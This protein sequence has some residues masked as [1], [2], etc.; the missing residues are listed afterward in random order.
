MLK[1]IS[2]DTKNN[3]NFLR[4]ENGASN[5]SYYSEVLSSDLLDNMT[6]IELFLKS[7][8]VYQV[9][10]KVVSLEDRTFNLS[11]SSDFPI[12]ICSIYDKPDVFIIKEFGIF[13]ETDIEKYPKIKAE[14]YPCSVK[15]CTEIATWTYMPYDSD[16]DDDN[17]VYFKDKHYC[18]KH[19]PKACSSC[20]SM[21]LSELLVEYYASPNNAIEELKP[22]FEAEAKIVKYNDDNTDI[23]LICKGFNNVIEFIQNIDDDLNL[24]GY[25][26]NNGDPCAE[27][28]YEENGNIV[29]KY[30]DAFHYA[31][32]DL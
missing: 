16:G 25:Y 19:V 3:V 11:D 27:Y 23:T 20:S 9:F 31:D 4:I 30:L 1:V 6:A 13:D 18:D 8:D 2:E 12:F 22:F 5:K 32:E 7:K 26:Y 28:M 15:N 10:V 29:F 14:V 21:E 24:K 17:K